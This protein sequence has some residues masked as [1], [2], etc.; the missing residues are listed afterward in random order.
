MDTVAV[1]QVMTDAPDPVVAALHETLDPAERARAAGF[2]REP[3]RRLFVL[4]HAAARAVCADRLGL[5][6]ERLRWEY[7]E[8]GKPSVPGLAMNLSHSGTVTLVAVTERREVG[9]DVQE[10]SPG[11]DATGMARRYFEAAE[12]GHVTGHADPSGAFAALWARK[13]AVIKAAGTR[14][15]RGLRIPVG[16][17][18]P[19]D[20]DFPVDGTPRPYRVDDLGAPDRHRAA[21]ALAGFEPYRVEHLI[22][23]P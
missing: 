17:H 7:G 6:P 9:V 15:M 21:I 20:V 10:V 16:L 18:G 14:L 19:A 3:D 2:R 11:L 1:W 12:A 22:W 5:R 13:E 23:V 8:H 4:A